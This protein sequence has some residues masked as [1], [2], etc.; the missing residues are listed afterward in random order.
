MDSFLRDVAHGARLMLAS[1]AFS[2][3]A[4]LTLAI[5]I[6]ANTVVF[7]VAHAMLFEGLPFPAADRLVMLW[8]ADAEDPS[9]LS[10]VAAPNYEDWT[11]LSTS[12]ESLGIWEHQTFNL[13]GPEPEQVSGLRASSSLFT[14]FGVPP[15]LGRTFTLDE[16]R[17]GH[18]VAIVSHRLWR[19]RFGEDPTV[20]NQT[21]R[22]NGRPFRIIG[23]MPEHFRTHQRDEVWIPIQFSERDAGR[24]SHSFYVAA[25]LRADVDFATAKAEMLTIGRQLASAYE[26]NAGE[27]ATVT[28]MNELGVAHLRGTLLMLLA[29]VLL[30]LLIACVNVANLLLV[31]AATRQR[32]FAIR[33]AL[34]AGRARLAL[35][36]LAEGLLL[37]LIGGA[38]GLLLA[39]GGTTAVAG[40]LPP[41]IRFAPF[42]SGAAVSLAP[43]VVVF[44]FV[45]ATLAGILFSLAPIVGVWRVSPDAVLRAGG[46]RGGTARQT[47]LRHSLVASEIALAVVLLVSAGLTIKS[48]TRVIAV[49]PGLDTTN[50]LTMTIALPQPDFYG[51]PERPHFCDDVATQVGSVPGVIAAGAI[52]HLPLSGANAS[53]GFAIEGRPDPPPGQGAGASYR[54]TCPGYFETLGIPIVA[55][56]DFSSDDTLRAPMVVMVNESTAAKYWP[57]ESPLGNRIKFGLLSSDTPWLTIVGV[58]KDVRHFG[59]D[60]DV[61]REIYRPYSQ[62]VWPL[63]TVTAKTAAEPLTMASAVRSAL[64]RIDSDQPVSNVRS[65]EQVL[66]ESLGARRF[67][68]QLLSSFSAIAFALAAIGVYGVVGY[69]VSLRTREIGIRM[70]LGARRGSVVRLMIARSLVPVSMGM[71]AGLAGA[72][73][74]GRF[75]EAFLFQV[76]PADPSVLGTIAA[77]LGS[78]A[79]VASWLPAR[80]AAR[81]D[82]ST[83]LREE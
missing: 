77:L 46:D 62:V 22:M 45:A 71:A 18:D 47:W 78:T 9:A 33:T 58:V 14:V 73:V 34:G 32:E 10:I 8:E 21:I 4:V 39:W 76:R 65:M 74:S 11:R 41:S 57:D 80:R 42:R 31:R 54:V 30:V 64:R 70:A 82:P 50:V 2:L 79:A 53:R 59:L 36:L 63:M 1:P 83:V 28:R 37:A 12:F 49:D 15:Q 38:A 6:G 3:V 52:S 61:S 68:V 20:L 25:R 13:G 67:P 35:Q 23:V 75:L 7:S 51:A 40:A 17:P 43:A 5:A 29:A 69:V 60:A 16:D 27:V 56:R 48:I 44:T 66:E 72:L 24:D 26:E 81:V 55:G 19:R